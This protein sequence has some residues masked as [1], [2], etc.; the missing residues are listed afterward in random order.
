MAELLHPLL[1][2]TPACSVVAKAAPLNYKDNSALWVHAVLNRLTVALGENGRAVASMLWAVHQAKT[3]GADLPKAQLLAH[4][5]S[6]GKGNAIRW[7]EGLDVLKDANRDLVKN[8]LESIFDKLKAE[9]LIVKIRPAAAG[10]ATP[11][12]L[13]STLAESYATMVEGRLTTEKPNIANNVQTAFTTLRAELKQVLDEVIAPRPGDLQKVNLLVQTQAAFPARVPAIPPWIE[14][15]YCYNDEDPVANAQ[16]ELHGGAGLVDQG[17]LSAAGY[18]YATDIPALTTF[19]FKQDPNAW[20]PDADVANI[21]MYKKDEDQKR[22]ANPTPRPGYRSAQ[23]PYFHTPPYAANWAR[24]PNTSKQQ[25]NNFSGTVWMPDNLTNYD[26]GDYTAQPSLGRLARKCVVN[27]TARCCFPSISNTGVIQPNYYP[28]ENEAVD[29]VRRLVWGDPPGVVPA[30]NNL[31]FW[32]VLVLNRVGTSSS[33]GLPDDE[34]RMRKAVLLELHRSNPTL[35]A[36]IEMLNS[37]GRGHSVG[38]LRQLYAQRANVEAGVAQNIT[39]TLDDLRIECHAVYTYNKPNPPNPGPLAGWIRDAARDVRDRLAAILNGGNVAN[40]VH[41]ILDPIFQSLN[42]LIPADP[43]NPF[44]YHRPATAQQLNVF[45]Q[46]ATP[47]ALAEPQRGTPPLWNLAAPTAIQVAYRNTAGGDVTADYTVNGATQANRNA[48]TNFNIGAVAGASYWFTH[49]QGNVAFANPYKPWTNPYLAIAQAPDGPDKLVDNF[50]ATVGVHNPGGGAPSCFFN[51]NDL[52]WAGT[53]LIGRADFAARPSL[54]KILARSVLVN[55]PRVAGANDVQDLTIALERLVTKPTVRADP[56]E[57]FRAAVIFAGTL[58]DHGA[59]I[60]GL[61]LR[62]RKQGSLP[63]AEFL[64]LMNLADGA[65]GNAADWLQN[66]IPLAADIGGSGAGLTAILNEFEAKLGVIDGLPNPPVSDALK[67][68]LQGVIAESQTVRAAIAGNIP[69]CF[70]V[71]A[72]KLDQMRQNELPIKRPAF[73]G[74]NVYQRE[75]AAFFVESNQALTPNQKEAI[76]RDIKQR[77][78]S[79]NVVPGALPNPVRASLA[80]DNPAAPYN[81]LF[82]SN[83]GDH[84]YSTLLRYLDGNRGQSAKTLAPQLSQMNHREF[85][86]FVEALPRPPWQPPVNSAWGGPNA[87]MGAMIQY[88]NPVDGTLIRYKPGGDEYQRPQAPMYSVE[89][90]HSNAGDAMFKVDPNGNAVP[91]GPGDANAAPYNGAE[92]SHYS[93]GVSR[94]GHRLLRY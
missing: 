79:A 65:H 41:Q 94:S 11:R 3:A 16:F 4:L 52:T 85:V 19:V 60:R 45:V 20:R 74:L 23:D 38:W 84:V 77:I 42:A 37:A 49:D 35:T 46:P 69:A 82:R 24:F 93:D 36:L 18:A 78:K 53:D 66:H 92:R 54:G 34:S 5:N 51:R 91:F 22:S 33:G 9:L 29:I 68:F 63:A 59:V 47:F 89:V 75:K 67:N 17:N 80:G 15:Q 1:L 13:S 27:N 56:D 31:L 43:L 48:A 8:S 14:V 83:H 90:T 62:V 39:S 40:K 26:A 21:P 30:P 72:A 57:W 70:G 76:D 25:Y 32:S 7:L 2:R 71:Y 88:Y 10:G 55:L 64:K 44:P 61:L 87:Q 50:L 28:E 6:A 81:Q 58:A 12:R 73:L 86:E